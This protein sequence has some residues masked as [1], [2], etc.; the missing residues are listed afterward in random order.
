MATRQPLPP[1]QPLRASA[2]NA[3]NRRCWNCDRIGHLARDC[4]LSK[5]VFGQPGR[6]N[7]PQ[8]PDQAPARQENPHPETAPFRGRDP[9]QWECYACGVPGHAR[10]GCP[11]MTRGTGRGTRY[12]D[13]RRTYDPRRR[14][15]PRRQDEPRNRQN[16]PRFQTGKDNVQ[17][18]PRHRLN[19]RPRQEASRIRK[20]PPPKRDPVAALR[21]EISALGLQTPARGFAVVPS[22]RTPKTK[23]T[24]DEEWLPSS[25]QSESPTVDDSSTYAHVLFYPLQQWAD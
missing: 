7:R 8:Q 11:L 24:S 3:A 19:L 21:K 1:R 12:Q 25:G 6:P 5:Q 14:Q 10:S 4:R 23:A 15:E 22:W 13:H 18:D 17:L 9:K 20:S 2:Q 16:R